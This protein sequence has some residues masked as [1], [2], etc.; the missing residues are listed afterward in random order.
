MPGSVPAFVGAEGFGAG[1]VGGRGGQVVHVTNL[2]DEGVGS[3]R[4]ALETVKGPRI[5]VFEVNGTITLSRQIL[6][7]DGFVTIAGQ[8]A[9]GN[10]IVIEGSR[11][12]ID[13]SEV[14]MRGLTFRPGDGSVGMNPDDRDGLFI[15]STD[16]VVKNVIVDHNSFEW[17]IDQNVAATGRVEHITF[18]NNIIAQGLDDSL[19]SKGPHSKGAG[20]GPWDTGQ[21]N[22][23]NH[24]SFIKNLMAS[25]FA[26][27][28]EI[29]SGD[30]IEMINNYIFNYGMAHAGSVLG[31]THKTVKMDLRVNAIGNVYEP[32]LD[33]PAGGRGPIWLGNLDSGSAVYLSDNLV[34][35]RPVD[36]AG[37][38]VQSS[39]Y[40]SSVGGTAYVKAEPGF[41]GSATQ[42]LDSQ[43]VAAYV[44]ANAGA[45][46]FARDEVD[47]RIIAGVADRSLRIVDSVVEAGGKAHNPPVA[48]APDTDRDGMPDWFEIKYGFNP[49]VADDKGD[50]DGDGYTN[51][52]EY[53]NGIYTGFDIGP[54]V[55]GGTPPVSSPAPTPTPP[56]PTPA[57]SAPAP[58]PSTP[59]PSTPVPPPPSPP[60]TPS[61]EALKFIYGTAGNDTISIRAANERA[62]E[63]PGG[64]TDLVVAY[65]DYTLGDHLENLSLKPGA[66]K[67]I[68]N[69]LA[70]QISGT[71]GNDMLDGRGGDDKLRGGQGDDLLFGGVGNDW[72]EGNEGNDFLF[73]GT[74]ADQL[75]GGAGADTFVFESGDSLATSRA[76]EDRIVDLAAGDRIVVDGVT[77]NL[78]A[79]PVSAVKAGNY[80]SAFAAAEAMTAK[81]SQFVVVHGSKDS[82]IFWDANRDGRVDNGVTLSLAAL[83]PD[84]W[85]GSAAAQAAVTKEA[86]SGSASIAET[87]KN[88]FGASGSEWLAT[89]A[90]IDRGADQFDAAVGGNALSFRPGHSFGIGSA[91]GESMF[92]FAASEHLS[93]GRAAFDLNALPE[94]YVGQFAGRG[95]DFAQVMGAKDGPAGWGSADGHFGAHLLSLA[96]VT[97]GSWSL[98]D[99][100]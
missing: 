25:N 24:I 50:N 92:G 22:A 81:G 17:A 38:Q 13:A 47:A 71:S 66:T 74:G 87:V 4:W 33:T 97:R 3:L 60:A 85:N 11:I 8:T 63:Q 45:R 6:V 9:P 20:T 23:N 52:E 83:N 35:G 21:W 70:N 67:G 15:G 84:I 18:S 1:T 57:P 29:G 59:V 14:I 7:E 88:L 30:K 53:I 40:W 91:A 93:L 48:A 75:L 86:L 69:E 94:V 76:A 36:A 2:N 31:T 54:P 46:P 26:R 64:G 49:N 10:G 100:F 51:I 80:A 44:L 68:G 41:A 77:L 96:P 82:W 99:A 16:N 95:G 28:P 43:Q 5:I 34:V 79:V 62:V 72:V 73:G 56:A 98:D 42:V 32:G 89:R 19:H 55:P 90:G 39:L 12:R 27:N 78:A 37:N 58:A 61:G 65:V